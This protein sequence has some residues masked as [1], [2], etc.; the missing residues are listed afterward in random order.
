MYLISLSHFFLM[1]VI[2]IPLFVTNNYYSFTYISTSFLTVFRYSRRRISLTTSNIDIHQPSLFVFYTVWSNVI[3]RLWKQVL[4]KKFAENLAVKY[5]F[6][7]INIKRH[8]KNRSRIM[9]L[10]SQKRKRIGEILALLFVNAFF[11]DIQYM[12][13][14]IIYRKALGTR[15]Q[16][17]L[18]RAD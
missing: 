17:I 10:W 15:F 8:C 2:S 6:L 11:S 4:S 18:F 5:L 1:V 16:I 7:R 14:H 9:R 3:V 12:Y 13:V